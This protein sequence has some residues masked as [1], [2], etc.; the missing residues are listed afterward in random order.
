[1][2]ATLVIMAAGIGSRFGTQEIKQLAPLGP[3]GECI[4]EYSIYD[5]LAVGFDKVVFII[6][7][8]I[9]KL[10]REQVGYKIEKATKVEYVFQ[11]LD[12]LPEGMSLP[13]G[14]KKPWGTGQAVMCCR[15]VVKE[16]FVVI[17]ADDFYGRD[18]FRKAYEYLQLSHPDDGKFHFCMVG[19]VMGNTLSD[20]GSVTRGVCEVNKNAHLTAVHE[21]KNIFKTP[22]GPVVRHE[23]GTETLLNVDAPVSMNIWGLTPDFIQRLEEGFGDFLRDQESKGYTGEYLLPIIIDGMIQRNQAKVTVLHTDSQWFGVTYQEDKET[24]RQALRDLCEA[25]EYPVPL[26]ENVR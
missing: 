9:E 24:T 1:M 2:S 13:K 16:P 3:D 25:G 19:F 6:R 23:D 17:N 20:N 12:M 14:R 8:D 22:Q 10:F 21:T 26:W 7:R 15:G 5:A 18:T 11:E 4:M